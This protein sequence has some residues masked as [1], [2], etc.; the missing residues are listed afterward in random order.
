[1]VLKFPA[2]EFLMDTDWRLERFSLFVL[3]TG[4]LLL[5][6]FIDSFVQYF[7]GSKPSRI[8]ESTL[9]LASATAL[10]GMIHVRNYSEMAIQVIPVW[11]THNESFLTQTEGETE[12]ADWVRKN[13]ARDSVIASN[14]FDARLVWATERRWHFSTPEFAKDGTEE[15]SRRVKLLTD[16][17][18]SPR[19]S[20][21][22]TL[23]RSGITHLTVDLR[24]TGADSPLQHLQVGTECFRNKSLV[25]YSLDQC[26]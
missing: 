9:L 18:D 7:R 13:V 21:L 10:L 20:S 11:S 26:P 23:R 5:S 1:M 4:M 3:V 14:N 25:V 19:Q 16:F 6:A 24:L 17:F 12:W 22:M 8:A 15:P 2:T